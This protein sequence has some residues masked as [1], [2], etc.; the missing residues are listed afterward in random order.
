MPQRYLFW[1]GIFAQIIALIGIMFLWPLL[2]TLLIVASID[3]RSFG[4]FKQKRIGQHGK[5]FNIYKFQTLH[6]D[7]KS[8]SNIGAFLRKYKLDELAQ[9]FNILFGE[10]CFVG[11]RPDIPGYYDVLQGEDRKVLN[12]KP[13]LTCEASIKYRNEEYL[14]KQ[15]Q[16][17]LEYNNQVIFPDKVKINLAY[18]HKLSPKED[19]KII[20]KTVLSFL[21]P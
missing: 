12:L 9:L 7:T 10:M 1:K 11:P 14:L 4:I 18:Y 2:L 15:Q 16:N 6:P 21:E 8:I 3:T 19:I 5:P 13:G 20:L 17:P